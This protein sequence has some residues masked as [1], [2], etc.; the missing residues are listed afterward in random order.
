M[1][2]SEKKNNKKNGLNE[3]CITWRKRIYSLYP[4]SLSWKKKAVFFIFLIFI[5][6]SFSLTWS[7]NGFCGVEEKLK[8]WATEVLAFIM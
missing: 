1:P 5:D 2:V 8:K 3:L 6:A 7:S 4:V